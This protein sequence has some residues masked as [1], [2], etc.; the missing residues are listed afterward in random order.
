M[1]AG[2]LFAGCGPILILTTYKSFSESDF[3]EKLAAKGIKKF[4]VYEV[5]VE[6]VKKKYGQHL[7]VI[8]NDLIQRFDFRVLD[9]NGFTV[10]DNF[11]FSDLGSPYYYEQSSAW[12]GSKAWSGNVLTPPS[13]RKEHL[14]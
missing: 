4:I 9:Y 13:K 6:L 12:K 1:K 11:S 3:I 10:F 8:I 5:P 7:D 14:I 2:V